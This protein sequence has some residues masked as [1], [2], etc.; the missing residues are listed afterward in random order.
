MQFTSIDYVPLSNID[1]CVTYADT[2][3]LS[4]YSDYKNTSKNFTRQVTHYCHTLHHVLIAVSLLKFCYLSIIILCQKW[5]HSKRIE[6]FH[7]DLCLLTIKKKQTHPKRIK[8]QWTTEWQKRPQWC[9][10]SISDIGQS[11]LMSQGYEVH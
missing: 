1:D 2:Y 11:V 6:S 10:T 4:Q 7:Q 5:S 3:Q 9:G 8:W